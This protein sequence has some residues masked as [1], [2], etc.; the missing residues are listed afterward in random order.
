MHKKLRHI[1][2]ITIWAVTS[3]G[4]AIPLC[5]HPFVESK[6]VYSYVR[7]VLM[8]CFGTFPVVC[9]VVMNILFA[10]TV[11][12]RKVYTPGTVATN[13]ALLDK[14]P[15]PIPD[16]PIKFNEAIVTK[17]NSLVQKIVATLL[18]CYT[19]HLMFTNYF[20]IAV[21]PRQDAKMTPNEVN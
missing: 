18:I 15:N 6:R 1:S 9:M 7:L 20:Y 5:I 19:P 16:T 3:L 10:W 4:Q 14:T 21:F 2:I 8:N 13:I 12:K 17:T 11:K